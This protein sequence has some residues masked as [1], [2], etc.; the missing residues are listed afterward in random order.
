MAKI[1]KHEIKFSV[2]RMCNGQQHSTCLN[3]G[4]RG[5]FFGADPVP[6]EKGPNQFGTAL[7]DAC[8]SHSRKWMVEQH[9]EW[10]KRMDALEKMVDDGEQAKRTLEWHMDDHADDDSF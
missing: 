7:H 5:Y 1:E 8:C 9:L 2:C 10:K 3:C 6:H 4:G